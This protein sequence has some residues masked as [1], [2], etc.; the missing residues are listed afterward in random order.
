MQDRIAG[1]L[2]DAADACGGVAL[3]DRPVLCKGQKPCGIFRGL[4]IG[5]VGAT[6]H[7]ID[8]LAIE[9]EGN[10][11]FDQR[12]D[13]TLSRKNSVSR[14]RDIAQMAGADGGKSN[15]TRTLHVDDAP[16]GKVALDG[17]RRFLLDL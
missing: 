14:R 9:F 16:P 1:S 13:L 5:I 8:L 12:L 6:L 3:E 4:P 15:S 17:A 10:A 11:E 7:V 2:A